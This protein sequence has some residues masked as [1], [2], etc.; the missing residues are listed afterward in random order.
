MAS[1]LIRGLIARGVPA[2]R[3]HATDIDEGKLA[4]LA[5]DCGI[6][7]GSTAMVTGASDVVVLAVKP[8]VM[9]RACE[10]VSRNL[11]PGTLVVSI[12]AGITLTSL[13]RWLGPDTALVRCMPNTPALVGLG[14]SGLYADE[15]VTSAQRALAQS[16]MDA[17]GLSLWLPKE[18]DL[19][20][21]TALS[22]SGPAYFFL[23][24]EAMQD[25]AIALG[26]EPDAARQL[27]L[28]T[29]LGA[30]QLASSSTVSTAELRRQVTSPGGTTERA[31]S[32]FESRGLR[33]LVKDAL[34]AAQQRSVELAR[35]MDK[36]D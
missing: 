3:L 29:A 36:P 12:A 31:I 25:A 9:A 6:N 1:A 34:A 27:T 28:Q 24:M 20:T 8:Q 22:G 32:V 30:A 21:V 7:T 14:A 18:A 4:S 13:R 11:A 5:A 16:I 10:A 19:D 33:A 35:D 26:L 2:T 15:T 17:V 23:L